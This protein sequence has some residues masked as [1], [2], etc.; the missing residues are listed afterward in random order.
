MRYTDLD[1]DPMRAACDEVYTYTMS[2]PGFILQHVVDAYAVQTANDNSGPL[3]VMFGW[4]LSPRRKRILGSSGTRSAN[5]D[6]T[7]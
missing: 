6:G 3:G 5:E 7:L 2:R 4:P 1:M